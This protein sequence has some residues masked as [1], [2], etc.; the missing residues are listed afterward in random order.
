MPSRSC[1]PAYPGKVAALIWLASVQERYMPLEL[2]REHG[3]RED[4]TFWSRST[5]PQRRR[6]PRTDTVSEESPSTSGMGESGRRPRAHR[7][8]AKATT[9][10]ITG[11]NGFIFSEEWPC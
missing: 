1:Q 7:M 5:L 11:R 3:A 10:S 2:L 6:L 4:L 9:A 8:G